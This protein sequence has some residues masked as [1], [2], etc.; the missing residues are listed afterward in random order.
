[1]TIFTKDSTYINIIREIRS[2]SHL[3]RIDDLRRIGTAKN[4]ALRRSDNAIHIVASRNR[5]SFDTTI[6]FS[7]F[8]P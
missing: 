2:G 4:V 7:A 5:A 6:E 1:M 3:F 8:R